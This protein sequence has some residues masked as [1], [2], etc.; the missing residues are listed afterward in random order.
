MFSYFF[1]AIYHNADYI[2]KGKGEKNRV[3]SLRFLWVYVFTFYLFT[4]WGI[5]IWFFRHPYP[6]IVY[7]ANFKSNCFLPEFLNSTVAFMFSPVPTNSTTFP[8]PKRWCSMT[9]PTC[10]SIESLADDTEVLVGRST[11]LTFLKFPPIW[12]NL[13]G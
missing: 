11:V 8:I 5:C 6:T 10:K 7:F 1:I 12:G 4:F 13:P 3:M 2:L 9:L